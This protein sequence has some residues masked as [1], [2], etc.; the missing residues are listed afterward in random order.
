MQDLGGSLRSGG[1]ACQCCDPSSHASTT[2]Y[3]HDGTPYGPAAAGSAAAASLVGGGSSGVGSTRAS[4]GGRTATSRSRSRPYTSQVLTP[5]EADWLEESPVLM[6]ALFPT[7]PDL[8]L[9]RGEP[10]EE[11]LAAHAR[12]NGGAGSTGSGEVASCGSAC[13]GCERC[14]F[15]TAG[16]AAGEAAEGAARKH[17]GS[18]EDGPVRAV[19]ALLDAAAVAGGAATNSFGGTRGDRGLRRSSVTLVVR[20]LA[21]AA[22]TAG[23]GG[24]QNR[25]SYKR[26]QAER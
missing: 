1:R 13:P 24:L 5:E 17:S 21:A 26:W 22:G 16:A 3:S 11:Q 25:H 15:P 4:S 20:Q 14:L 6:E 8:P 7:M 10:W 2:Y 9:P 19:N 12:T 18:T 23:P